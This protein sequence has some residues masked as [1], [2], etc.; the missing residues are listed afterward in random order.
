MD[1]RAAS[2]RISAARGADHGVD[3][4]EHRSAGS[5]ARADSQPPGPAARTADRGTRAARRPATAAAMRIATFNINGITSRLPALLRWLQKTEPD[6]ACL[7]ELKAPDHRFPV[8]ALSEAGYY[9]LW[10]G[11]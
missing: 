4:F 5:R 9:A 2:G 7:Q 3:W 6:V 11:Q 1:P 8:N 10:H